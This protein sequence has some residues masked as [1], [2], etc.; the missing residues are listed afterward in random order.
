MDLAYKQNCQKLM[1]DEGVNASSAMKVGYES[2]A[3]SSYE[4][5][6][7]FG[8]VPARG[9]AEFPKSFIRLP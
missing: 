9:A 4:F 1:V 7:V 8:S 2:V 3:Q 6:R 5:K